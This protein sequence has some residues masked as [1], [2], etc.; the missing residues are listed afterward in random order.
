MILDTWEVGH[1]SSGPAS[2][3]ASD[4]SGSPYITT[5][6]LWVD[7]VVVVVFV[8]CFVFGHRG[9]LFRT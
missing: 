2:L 4:T 1:S 6:L 8:Y 5:G 3:D 9:L 7:F